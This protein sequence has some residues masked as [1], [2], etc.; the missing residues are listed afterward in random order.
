MPELDGSGPTDGKKVKKRRKVGAGFW[1]KPLYLRRLLLAMVPKEAVDGATV[2]RF[3]LWLLGNRSVLS[4]SGSLNVGLRWL[5][6][7]L[8][9]GLCSP[10]DPVVAIYEL[11]FQAMETAKSEV[12]QQPRLS[13]ESQLV[14]TS[15]HWSTTIPDPHHLRHTVQDDWRQPTAGDRLEGPDAFETV[16]E[17][18]QPLRP[19][20]SLEQISATGPGLGPQGNP[21]GHLFRDN[22]SVQLLSTPVRLS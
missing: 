2:A 19:R 17:S 6:C 5:N 13:I 22:K 9:H 18:R 8:H 14:L 21:K 11:F 7:V 10:V 16:A 15:K 1:L 3:S 12:R 4:E 20:R